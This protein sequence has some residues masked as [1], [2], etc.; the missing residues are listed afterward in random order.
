MVI[1]EKIA[2]MPTTL[3]PVRLRIEGMTC[4]GCVDRVERALQEV[5]GVAQARVNLNTRLAT[6]ELA[7]PI[8]APN[9][10]ID[11]V[12]KAGYD[13][14]LARLGLDAASPIDRDH[15]EQLRRQK[16]AMFQ[17]IAVAVP[18][19]GLHWLAPRLQ[20]HDV[21]GHVWPH[22]I[23]G[24]LTAMLLASSAGAPI[25]VSGLRAAVFRIG[26]MD[27][28]ITL[29]VSA[30]FIAGLANV[31]GGRPDAADFH[32]AAMI[33]AFINVG[34]YLE[35]RARHS[36]ASGLA[37][38]VHRMPVTAMRVTQAGIEQIPAGQVRMGDRILVPQ[39]Y[40]VPVDGDVV[41]GEAAVDESV[42]T[43]EPVPRRR[44]VGESV[45]SGMMVREGVLTLSATRVGADSTLGR[46]AR[47][48]EEAQAGKTAMQRLADRVAGVFVPIVLAF[49]LITLLATCFLVPQLGFSEAVQRAVAVLVISCPCAMG[50]A[51]PTAVMVATARAAQSGILVRDAAA[52]ERAA[53]VDIVLVDKTGTLTMGRPRVAEVK[54]ASG[55]NVDSKEMLRLAASVEQFSQHPLA[56][57]VVD[58]A[59]RQNMQLDTPIAFTS[60]PGAGLKAQLHGDKIIIGSL[61]FLVEQGVNVVLQEPAS[62]NAT[63]AVR[64]IAG[65]ARNQNF[66]GT[67]EFED[68]LRP[69]AAEG[70]EAL[71]KMGMKLA[72]LSGDRYAAVLAVA[73]SLGIN[74]FLADL[75]P[76]QKVEEVRRH[77]D[78]GR[79]V[80]MVGDGINDA[81][82]LA[83]AAIGITFSSATDLA[84]GAAAVTI[85]HEDLRKLADVFAL[86]RHGVRI[87]RQNLFWAFFY[88][89][90][91]IPMAATGHVAPGV[92]A[93]AMMLSSI[94]VVLNSLRLRRVE[95]R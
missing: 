66:L 48:V 5:P 72:L 34:R 6:I 49:S 24:L 43:G 32:A 83:E 63:L 13:A 19:M 4:G 20:S 93:A 64:A 22:A 76:E 11:A 21:G 14:E 71:R 57:A 10:L 16:Q 94:S 92:A 50:L 58:A 18:I 85:I 38:L 74:D 9:L 25:L 88:N 29:G 35:L 47:A 56:R 54:P 26:N 82:A 3:A 75:S 79:R 41:A 60:S 12:R 53:S 78:A 37:T 23:Q 89:V 42:L 84:V 81:A 1:E 15:A 45:A 70:I 33:L 61:S 46:I 80:A 2:D 77:H 17:A 44:M 55:T 91:A 65:L 40:M 67:I 86:A 36:A 52:Y 28:L 73:Q 30:A 68:S 95:S 59:S 27:L 7:S 8:V 87:I 62:R 51:T 90:L 69:H 39:D 31:V